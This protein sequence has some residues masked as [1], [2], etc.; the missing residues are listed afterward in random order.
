MKLSDN[1]MVCNAEK[2]LN[3]TEG[4]SGP[5]MSNTF[6]PTDENRCLKDLTI[7]T[8]SSHDN[9]PQTDSEKFSENVK[10]N[11]IDNCSDRVCD[12]KKNIAPRTNLFGDNVFEGWGQYFRTTITKALFGGKYILEQFL[13]DFCGENL[14]RIRVWAIFKE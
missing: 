14:S 7:S 5:R 4:P 11:G 8:K 9:Y 2:P 10:Y 6:K 1:A 12:A 3:Y 13:G